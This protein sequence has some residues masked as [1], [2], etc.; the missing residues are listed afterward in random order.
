MTFIFHNLSQG[1]SREKHFFQVYQIFIHVLPM[2]MFI[3]ICYNLSITVI[4]V[5]TNM[6]TVYQSWASVPKCFRVSRQGNG[7]V[8]REIFLDFFAETLHFK[9]RDFQ[10]PQQVAS[11]TF[12][13]V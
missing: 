8:E 11:F 9:I 5:C 10:R 1:A 7:L 6:L 13:S 12:A 4:V 2:F 3:L